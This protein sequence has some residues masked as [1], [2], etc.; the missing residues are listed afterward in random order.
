MPLDE[1]RKDKGLSLSA[2]AREL[3]AA[4]ATVV[5]RW[6]LPPGHPEAQIPHQKYM[7]AIIE[8][9]DGKVQPNDFYGAMPH[10]RR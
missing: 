10:D 3:G 4:H 8:L 7:Y 5:R 6:C 9:S 1:F 2:L